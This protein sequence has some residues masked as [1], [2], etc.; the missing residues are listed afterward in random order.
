MIA[1]EQLAVRAGS[2]AL[3]DISFTV[4]TGQHGFLMG[5]TGSGKTTLLE[6]ICGLKRVTAGRVRLMGEDVTDLK[7]ARR[8]IGYVPQDGAL[9]GHLTV[10]DHLG[11][12]LV[13]RRWPPAEVGRR[14]AELADLLGLGEL[15][16]R[17]PFGLSGGEARRVALGRALAYRPRVLCLDEPLSALDEATRDEMCQVLRTVRRHTGVTILH[18]SH[19]PTEARRLAD[20]LFVLRD[21]RVKPAEVES[22]DSP[23]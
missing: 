14:V 16:G 9:F 4:P 12:A 17:R 1:V 2:F 20:C 23:C 6:A 13:I 3:A 5:R 22:G 8:G 19:S 11:F 7:P 10:R 21:G 15:L 18:V